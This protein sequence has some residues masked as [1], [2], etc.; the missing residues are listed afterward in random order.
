MPVSPEAS[1]VS[2]FRFGQIIPI[3][4]TPGTY[5]LPGVF[6]CLI[7]IILI[8]YAFSRLSTEFM[9]WFAC[10]SMDCAACAMTFA[11]L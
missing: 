7:S 1:I 9:L 6:F 8:R 5:P 4:E 3:S 11:L 10:A 2:M